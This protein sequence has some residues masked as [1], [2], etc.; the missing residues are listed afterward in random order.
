MCFRRASSRKSDSPA[1]TACVGANQRKRREMV[2]IDAASG[3][4][5]RIERRGYCASCTELHRDCEAA[6]FEELRQRS[7][8]P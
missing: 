6:L 8:T 3:A 4:D 2:Q 1:G 7:C 5:V